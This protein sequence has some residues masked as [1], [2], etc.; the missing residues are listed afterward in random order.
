MHSPAI[1]LQGPCKHRN[2]REYNRTIMTKGELLEENERML[3]LL[4]DIAKTVKLPKDL[5]DR[6]EEHNW[7]REKWVPAKE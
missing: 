6:I 5:Q 4:E 3:K 7:T 1:G 2:I